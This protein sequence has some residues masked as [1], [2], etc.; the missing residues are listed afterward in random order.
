MPTYPS[1]LRFERIV[2][3]TPFKVGPANVY[4][5]TADPIT[6]IDSG[7]NTP[8]TE[9]ALLLD[10]PKLGADR[11]M[12]AATGKLL[13]EEG[14]PME[15]LLEM[16]DRERR[17]DFRDLHP[18]VDGA[19][20]LAGGQVLRFDGFDLE[21]L[22]LPGHTAGHICLLDR[23]S[24]VLFSG[25]TLLL[26]ITPNPLL[27]PDPVSPNERRRSL[28]EYVRTLDVLASLPL[29]RVYPG[30]GEPIDDP[31]GLIEEMRA[32]HRSRAEDL[33][34]RLTAEGLTS[35]QLATQLFPRLEGF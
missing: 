32:H 5:I 12:L 26:D 19:E 24:G 29:E 16:G 17:R 11:S 25:D 22:H 13:L 2:V 4:A 21:V 35:W 30:H 8:E 28:L 9:N 14:V 33:E 7:T 1:G 34:G 3:P 23:A 20:P 10:L 18:V 15:T 27:E 31:R 6:L